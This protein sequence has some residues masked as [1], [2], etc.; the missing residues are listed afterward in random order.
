MSLVDTEKV[1]ALMREAAQTIIMPLYAS[2]GDNDIR[3]KGTSPVTV[4]DEQTEVLYEQRL[5]DLLP[6]STV[7]GEES[8][9]AGRTS[10]EALKRTEKGVWVVDPLDG[11]RNFTNENKHFAGMIALVFNGA[12]RMSWIHDIPEDE[13]VVAEQGAGAYMDGV[14]VQTAPA[15]EGQH[16]EGYVGIR[17]LPQVYRYAVRDEF[18]H[19]NPD[20]T[21]PEASIVGLGST[22]HEYLDLIRGNTQ[23]VL[24]NVKDNLWDYLAGDLAVQEAGGYAATSDR[25]NMTVHDRN[26]V[27]LAAASE[28]NGNRVHDV[29]DRILG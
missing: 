20:A 1:S 3:F 9:A 10:L 25:Q 21:F 23:F 22:A 5:V 18:G 28:E 16:L 24:S 26:K 15:A 14:R 6:G 19:S 8:I 12:V 29:I 11:T 13:V 7:I 27:L 17:H 2:L 4:A